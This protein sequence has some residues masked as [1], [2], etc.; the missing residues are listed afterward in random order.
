MS[1]DF[2]DPRVGSPGINPYDSEPVR[3]QQKSNGARSRRVPIFIDK[4][5]K[6][7]LEFDLTEDYLAQSE[8]TRTQILDEYSKVKVLAVQPSAHF[9]SRDWL[10]KNT[11]SQIH[12]T[13]LTVD[14]VVVSEHI[15]MSVHPHQHLIDLG[16]GELI[17]EVRRIER[18]TPPT[19]ETKRA[20]EYIREI[21]N[22]DVG[23]A[24][25]R[26]VQP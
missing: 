18:R 11:G 9:R 2:W 25:V 13:V 8:L 23:M 15:S 24:L 6:D 7:V 22:R 12:S 17:G 1:A 19:P 10:D 21:L 4:S 5:A 20:L 14:A 3:Y 26:F 16:R